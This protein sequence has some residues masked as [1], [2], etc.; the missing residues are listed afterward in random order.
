MLG[1]LRPRLIDVLEGLRPLRL[2]RPWACPILG[3]TDL[4]KSGVADFRHPS[5]LWL[6]TSLPLA[7]FSY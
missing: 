6:K 7:G 3:L 2:K 5:V 4:R 1:R